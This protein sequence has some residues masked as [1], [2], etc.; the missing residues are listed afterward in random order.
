MTLT[1]LQDAC[2][3]IGKIAK[4]FPIVPSNRHPVEKAAHRL[5]EEIS[6][7]LCRESGWNLVDGTLR[8]ACVVAD[9][10]RRQASTA[11]GG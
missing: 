11:S 3:V 4:E 6:V 8:D 10:K 9:M 7:Y 2:V 1:E 5:L